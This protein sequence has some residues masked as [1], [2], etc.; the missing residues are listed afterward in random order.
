MGNCPAVVSAAGLEYGDCVRED[1]AAGGGADRARRRRLIM[2]GVV[3]VPW[4]LKVPVRLAA[5]MLLNDSNFA[6]A[7]SGRL[8]G[9]LDAGILFSSGAIMWGVWA[10]STAAGAAAGSWAG[11][12]RVAA[13]TPSWPPISPPA[14]RCC[15]W[16]PSRRGRGSA[17]SG[18]PPLVGLG[19]GTSWQNEWGR[20]R[21]AA[22][23]TSVAASASRFSRCSSRT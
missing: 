10:A 21:R 19:E 7:T 8:R 18:C 1:A 16:R 13:S 6:Y 2:L 17:A 4:L 20:E 15:R 14:S 9:E 22:G 5:V 12:C 3:R 23:F 11:T